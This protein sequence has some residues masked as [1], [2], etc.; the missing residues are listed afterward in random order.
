MSD[1]DCYIHNDDGSTSMLVT[2]VGDEMCW[3][4]FQDVGDDFGHFGHQHRMLN[5][6]YLSILTLSTNIQKMSPR[7]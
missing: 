4:K 7:S 5:I 1:H 6:L 3:S 2:D